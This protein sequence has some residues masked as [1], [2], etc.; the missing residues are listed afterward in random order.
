[1]ADEA[2]QQMI[3]QSCEKAGYGSH[4]HNRRT[5]LERER[6]NSPFYVRDDAHQQAT[7]DSEDDQSQ[8]RT[9]QEI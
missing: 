6:G 9:T 8:E 2:S 5:S 7:S 1:L 3:D 4:E